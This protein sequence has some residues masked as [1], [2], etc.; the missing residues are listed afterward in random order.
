MTGFLTDLRIAGRTLVRSPWFTTLAVL[1]LALGIGL[2]TALFGLVDAVLLRALPFKDPDRL[3]EIWGQD[4]MRSGMRV[5]GPLVE[6]LRGRS[7]SLQA[8][9]IHGPVGGVLRTSAGPTDIRGDHVSANYVGV[10]GV[11]PLVGRAFRPDEDGPGAAPVMLVSYNFWQR[12]LGGD[13]AAVGTALYLDSL[14]YTV[15]GIMPPEFR[16]HFRE[17]IKHDYW[18][19]HVKEQIRQ[20]ELEEGY[21]LVARL[22]PGV[23]L[24]AARRELQA[25]A[26]TVSV[27]GW[28]AQGRRLG[29]VRLKN[30]VVGDSARALK[31][32]L[33]AVAVVLAIVCANLALLLLARSDKRVSEFATRKA[34]GAASAQVF[35]LALIES[36]LLAALGGAAGVALAYTVLPAIRAL[37]PAD[38]PRIADSAVNWRALTVA[39][40]CTLLTGCAFGIAP[41]LRLSRLSVMQALKRAPGR[42]SNQTAWLRSVLVTGQVAGSLALCILAGLVGRTFLTLLPTDPGFQARSLSVFSLYL[43]NAIYPTSPDR[44]RLYE[45]MVR[46]LEAKPGVASAAFAENVPFS[47]DAL[48]VPVRD[49]RTAVTDSTGVTA[50]VRAV[51]S[52]YHQLLQIPLRKGRVFTAADREGSVAVAIVNETLARKLGAGGDVIGQTL[53]LG[54]PA[55]ARPYQIVG[56]AAD[57][58]STG[59]SVD[60]T[61]EVHVPYGQ[62]GNNF[63][64]LIVRSELNIG[65]LTRMLRAEVRAAAPELPMLASRTAVPMSQLVRQ[66]LAGPRFSATLATAFSI[67]AT[68]LA[69]MGVFGLVSYAVAQRRQE[70]GI[71]SALGARPRDLAVTAVQPAVALTAVGI[72]LGLTLAAFLTRFIE[73][74]LYAIEPLDPTTFIGAGALLLVVAGL[75][76]AI[77]ARQAMRVDPMSTLR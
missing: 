11:P 70:F 55:S 47:G 27:E 39:L 10:L 64:F 18:T 3:V 40:A 50:D 32:M 19:N 36:L 13:P 31:L 41:A 72:T 28:G 61:N 38:I 66:A 57:A 73:K 1:T 49:A 59:T 60:I 35:R 7:R 12:H 52:N 75:A 74:Q 25:I 58:R 23:T 77:P 56:V 45:E 53:L 63:G 67:V 26:A 48:R 42:V 65:Q 69:A 34:I 29:L 22:A 9:A 2:N 21:E 24:E 44:S 20:F 33:A 5:P 37:A 14:A 15:V 17:G 8:I 54:R 16:T 30:E 71:R 76:A 68:L 43:P 46:R 62:R 4:Q 51:S 6:A